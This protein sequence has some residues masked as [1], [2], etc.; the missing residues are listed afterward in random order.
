MKKKTTYLSLPYSFWLAVFTIIPMIIV[1]FYAFTD[2]D[3]NFTIE[4]F[5]GMSAYAVVFWRSFKLAVL[6]TVV[7]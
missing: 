3:G 4:N 1:I 7:K 6:S 2:G 5:T